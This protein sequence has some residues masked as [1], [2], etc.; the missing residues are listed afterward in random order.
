MM[1]LV[2]EM[3]TE[4][5]MVYTNTLPVQ[6]SSERVFCWRTKKI[7]IQCRSQN[8]RNVKIT[9]SEWARKRGKNC[10]QW[11]KEKEPTKKNKNRQRN[12]TCVCALVSI[13]LRSLAKMKKHTYFFRETNRFCM[14]MY[15]NKK[16]S[17]I[18]MSIFI[19]T[20]FVCWLGRHVC[21]VGFT[22]AR[23]T[24]IDDYYSLS[25]TLMSNDQWP[26]LCFW[27]VSM[28]IPF[29]A[30]FLAQVFLS[31]DSHSKFYFYF[32][33]FLNWP[34]LRESPACKLKCNINSSIQGRWTWEKK[35]RISLC[36]FEVLRIG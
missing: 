29:H 4:R 11:K 35:I 13:E 3:H 25:S 36:L 20:V 5:R 33:L 30:F 7:S 17:A 19:W 34:A 1:I 24:Y 14:Q 22:Y 10:A 6:N 26:L 9:Y 32:I 15:D 16:Y 23:I 12:D 2:D 27:C 28:F 18:K 31:T 8:Q 21:N